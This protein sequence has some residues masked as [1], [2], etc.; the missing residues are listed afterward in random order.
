L[1]FEEE[2]MLSKK[3]QDENNE[4]WQRQAA[5]HKLINSNLRLVIKIAGLYNTPGISIMDLIQEGN[6]GL[7]CAAKKFDYRKNF[8]FC[9]YASWWIRQYISRYISNKRRLV[10][11]PERKEETMRKI[12]RTYHVLCQTLKHQPKTDDIAKELGISVH[13]VNSFVNMTTDIND[14]TA[15][16]VDVHEDYTYSPER[17]L[18]KQAFRDGT[19]RMLNKLKD[20]EKRVLSYRYQLNGCER[21]TLREIG[22][23]L[24]ISPETV[25]KMEQRALKKIRSHVNELK[26]CLYVEAI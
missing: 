26:E 6:I 1:T 20:K 3:I 14:E 21:H 25:R 15:S 18:M 16:V 11:L 4:T 8:R 19:M 5:L 12:Q 17:D 9:T 13:D 23:I 22:N 24:N 2:L 7:I 10:R